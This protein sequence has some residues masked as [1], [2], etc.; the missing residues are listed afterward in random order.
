MFRPGDEPVPGYRLEEVLGRGG[1]GEVWRATGP[2]ETSV[3]LKLIGLSGRHGPKEF[4]AVWRFK[5]IRHAH[6]LPITALWLLDQHRNVLDI[7]ALQALDDG[8]PAA[9][10][11]APETDPRWPSRP[12][13]LVMATVLGDKDLADLLQEYRRA[14]ASGIPPDELID[15]LDPPGCVLDLRA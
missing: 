8:R 6:L 13:T 5:E 11:R 7:S 15:Y 1:S 14:G 2:G 3:A 9:R 4:Q 10:N 12:A